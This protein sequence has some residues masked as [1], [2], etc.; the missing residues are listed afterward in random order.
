MEEGGPSK[1]G[2]CVKNAIGGDD[3][4]SIVGEILFHCSLHFKFP[5]HSLQTHH[6]RRMACA[7]ELHLILPSISTASSSSFS[8]SFCSPV[9][10]QFFARNNCT[11]A[12]SLSIQ[13]AA[14]SQFPHNFRMITLLHIIVSTLTFLFTGTPWYPHRQIEL[15]TYCKQKTL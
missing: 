10:T 15:L 14:L 3:G 13:P 1:G 8:S 11:S 6:P 5:S 12:F 4:L 2:G 9:F 7:E